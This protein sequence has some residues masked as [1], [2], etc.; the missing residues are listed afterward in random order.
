LE[1]ILGLLK[2]LKIPSLGVKDRRGGAKKTGKR[3]FKRQTRERKKTGK[4]RKK[5]DKGCKKD[6]QGGVKR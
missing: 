3:D 6:R 4:G 1:S 5:T 2:S